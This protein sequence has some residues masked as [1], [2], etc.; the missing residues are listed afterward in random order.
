MTYKCA[1]NT[2]YIYEREREA[3]VVRETRG[4]KHSIPGFIALYFN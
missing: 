1:M 2:L 3:I 4:K